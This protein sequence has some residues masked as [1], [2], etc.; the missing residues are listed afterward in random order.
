MAPENQKAL[1][2][3]KQAIAVLTNSVKAKFTV[4]D[5]LHEINLKIKLDPTNRELR[6]HRVELELEA[7][8]LKNVMNQINNSAGQASNPRKDGSAS[9]LG[10]SGNPNQDNLN[11]DGSVVGSEGPYTLESLGIEVLKA[12]KAFEDLQ[13]KFNKEQDKIRVQGTPI[14]ARPLKMYTSAGPTNSSLV[15]ELEVCKRL[16]ISKV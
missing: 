1:E 2:L 13:D 9:R 4:E 16:N 15:A 6:L 11:P 3:G 8:S 5:Q 12:K 14:E 10:S 7:H